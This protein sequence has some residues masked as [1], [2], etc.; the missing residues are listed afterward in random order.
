[1]VLN[2]DFFDGRTKSSQR[3]ETTYNILNGMV[4]KSTLLIKI[5]I[6]FEKLIKG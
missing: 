6:A 2:K 5:V 1:M 3:S 4:N